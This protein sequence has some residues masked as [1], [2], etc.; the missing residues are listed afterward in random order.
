MAIATIHV[1]KFDKLHNV[2]TIFLRV[3][4]HFEQTKKST[5]SGPIL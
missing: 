2:A 5:V 4:F 3:E 1:L